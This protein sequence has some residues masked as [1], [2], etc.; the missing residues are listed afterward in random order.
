MTKFKLSK[1]KIEFYSS[2]SPEQ[3]NSYADIVWTKI[4]TCD[5]KETKVRLEQEHAALLDLYAEV[6]QIR[7]GS[8]VELQMGS[9]KD[10]T[11]DENDFYIVEN[12]MYAGLNDISDQ[13][14]LSVITNEDDGPTHI[15]AFKPVTTEKFQW[16][17]NH[18]PEK[19]I[20]LWNQPEFKLKTNPLY[21][22]IKWPKKLKEEKQL[23]D[24]LAAIG[25]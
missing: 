1:T 10:W 6:F 22:S 4:R 3:F 20:M 11:E 21:K 14:I 18:Y 7:I 2:L 12:F 8:L 5:R 19:M 24:D 23:V 16:M 25:L 17:V 13:P 15:T 9:Y